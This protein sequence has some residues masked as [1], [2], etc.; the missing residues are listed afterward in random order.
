M[1]S[2]ASEVYQSAAVPGYPFSLL[3]QKRALKS[4]GQLWFC[5]T[6]SQPQ[7]VTQRKKNK[8]SIS[9]EAKVALVGHIA[10]RTDGRWA[11]KVLEWR[12]RFGKRSVLRP[13]TWWI[14]VRDGKSL[15]KNVSCTQLNDLI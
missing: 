14:D 9:R 8:S 1:I 11:P 3:E 7:V 4:T 2:K 15:Q 13:P 12:H 5:V 10:Q 6:S